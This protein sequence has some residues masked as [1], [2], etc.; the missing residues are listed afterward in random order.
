MRLDGTWTT[1]F[2]E[3]E[4]KKVGMHKIVVLLIPTRTFSCVLRPLLWMF[5][6]SRLQL[7]KPVTNGWTVIRS[8]PKD[9]LLVSVARAGA[10]ASC[11]IDGDKYEG[12][13]AVVRN[14]K[15]RINMTMVESV[16]S[17]TPHKEWPTR[18]ELAILTDYFLAHSEGLK[19]AIVTAPAYG[20]THY[21]VY[22]DAGGVDT[23]SMRSVTS[24]MPPI[25]D[26]CTA[27]LKTAADLE[28]AVDKRIKRLQEKASEVGAPSSFVTNCLADFVD[29]VVRES[30]L[31]PD[32]VDMIE[33]AQ[34]TPT[35]LAAF[36]A[37]AAGSSKKLASVVRPFVK[38]EAYG[39]ETERLPQDGADS[40]TT[41]ETVKYK[42]ARVITP[43]TGAARFEYA[44]Y[45]YSLTHHIKNN[46]CWYAFVVPVAIMAQL[47]NVCS[48]ADMIMVGDFSRFDGT[49]THVVRDYVER[50]ILRRLFDGYPEVDELHKAQYNLKGRI[51]RENGSVVNYE[52][53]NSR[54]SG[55]GETSVFNTVVNAACAY[56]AFRHLGL[57]RQQAE[58]ALTRCIFG[59]DDS[60]VAVPLG[61]TR[62]AFTAAYQWASR[63]LGLNIKVD[64]ADRGQPVPFLARWFMPWYDDC[65]SMCDI[66]RQMTKLHTTHAAH[67]TKEVKAREKATS[68]LAT[69]AK[70]PII[71]EWA[72]AVVARYGRLEPEH[73][74]SW[75]SQYEVKENFLNYYD[76][77]WMDG[78]IGAYC[79]NFDADLF[80]RSI[81]HDPL[82]VPNCRTLPA[83][84]PA[85]PVI[86]RDEAKQGPQT[87]ELSENP[88]VGANNDQKNTPEASK[89]KGGGNGG[90]HT[91]NPRPAKP[92][93]RG[94]N[95]R[96]DA[97][98]RRNAGANPDPKAT[99]KAKVISDKHKPRKPKRSEKQPELPTVT[100]AVVAKPPAA[101]RKAPT[102]CAPKPAVRDTS[103]LD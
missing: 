54:S 62:D 5:T 86:V 90:G 63:A 2:F 97:N 87:S 30:S 95:P 1:T 93:A 11:T 76:S 59:G 7:F 80:A 88:A 85:E 64:Y 72:R 58:E 66:E 81:R 15:T 91:T 20:V 3:V 17:R 28:N 32:P 18:E 34:K 49:I 98:Q 74:G 35:R 47:N 70:T 68:I 46:F 83:N 10:L 69:D 73:F 13:L 4:K 100:K 102:T 52:T 99:G 79:E 22:Q 94:P 38:A 50:P 44:R 43:F 84:N 57:N 25:D 53:G 29:Y 12:A 56:L 101:A 31:S 33:V 19:Q 37:W 82:N 48:E 60:A 41:P 77:S 40:S 36:I 65:N 16:Y 61:I 89:G 92:N 8:H 67:F 75:W 96:A 45:C 21:T 55:S 27:P 39:L 24:F 14:A 26:A 78:I 103:T 9:S 42:D 71:G 23:S 51:V 6:A